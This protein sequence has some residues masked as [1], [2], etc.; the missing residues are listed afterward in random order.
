MIQVVAL[1]FFAGGSYQ[2]RVGQKYLHPMCQTEVCKSIRVVS[3]IINLHLM[4]AW[5][6]YPQ[7]QRE[8][9][10]IKARFMEK[11]RFPGVIGAIDGTHIA[12]VPPENNREHI[13]FNRKHFHSK[14]VQVV[15]DYDLK[16][17]AVNAQHGGRAHDSHIWRASR[18]RQH[19]QECHQQ[20][21]KSSWL[22]GDSAYPL[23]PWLMTPFIGPH[24]G[25]P[26]ARYNARFTRARACVE[27]CFGVWKGWF[28]CLRRDR[29]LHY[30]PERAG[31]TKFLLPAFT[32]EN[33][34]NK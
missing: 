4:A 1:H 29:A 10:A 2:R 15:C 6:R 28:R 7:T 34:E 19:L 5:V 21:D 30:S 11:I 12:I 9:F 24:E 16:I 23:E 18:L 31:C 25:T 3:D 22:I 20:G 32:F 8:K 13:Y 14:N 27:R 26:E 17:I 33:L